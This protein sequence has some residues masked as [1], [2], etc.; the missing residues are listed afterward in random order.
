MKEKEYI[1][2]P[3][4]ARILGISRVAVYKKIKKGQIEARKIGRNYA[5]P[6]R[7]VSVIRGRTLSGKDKEIIDKA[8]RKT[9]KEYAEVLKLLGR[10]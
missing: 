4:F 1:S 6:R 2:I 8:V 10:E 7:Y 9:F 3:E 5:I